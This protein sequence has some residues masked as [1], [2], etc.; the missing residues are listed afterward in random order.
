[1]GNRDMILELFLK[2]HFEASHSLEER[3]AEHTHRWRVEAGVRGTPHEGRLISLPI[4][5]NLLEPVI[6]E[7]AGT[8]LNRNPNLDPSS[9]AYPTCENLA[10]YLFRSFEDRLTHYLETNPNDLR[11]T[12]VSVAVDELSGEETGWA[13][14]SVD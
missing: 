13:R 5:R 11:M 4:L 2:L 12:S 3:E 1:L 8:Y 7:L 6:G 10:V 9:Q 14:L